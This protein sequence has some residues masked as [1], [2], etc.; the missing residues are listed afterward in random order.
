[1]DGSSYTGQRIGAASQFRI[2]TALATA[3]PLR[4]LLGGTG[5]PTSTPGNLHA[6]LLMNGGS[7]ASWMKHYDVGADFIED[8][9]GLTA[10]A[11]GNYAVCGYATQGS[12]FYGLLMKV[13][14]NGNV[15]WCRKLEDVS[16]GLQLSAIRELADGSLLVCGTNGDYDGA[17][18]KVDAN[19]NPLWARRFPGDRLV[20]FTT[21][22][23][24]L[25]VCGAYSR[26]ELD[27]DGQGCGFTDVANLT[28]TT[29]NPNVV[30]MTPT[31]TAFAPTTT[32]LTSQ[33]RI[34]EL[35][36]SAGCIYSGMD[37]HKDRERLAVYP[38]PSDGPVW[39]A[40]D[41][42][43][44]DDAV[45]LRDLMGQEVQRTTYRDGLDL[46]ALPAGS[47]Y[48]EVLRTGSRGKVVRH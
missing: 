11:D 29:V 42:V 48:L 36:F 44:T 13:D 40:G 5:T 10:T 22:G 32:A 6:M 8:I 20:R 16:G 43:R 14:P 30:D 4:H 3:D 34:P 19:G 25:L 41:A 27:A 38:V 47:Y 31:I 39:I 12:G 45:L 46:T 17:L 7:G 1:P 37:E 21:S 35:D 33:A 24:T 9:Y 18:A 23:S 28:A 2:Y 26:I 15:L